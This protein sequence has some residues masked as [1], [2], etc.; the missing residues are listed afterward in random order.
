M[1]IRAATFASALAAAGP[2]LAGEIACW[3]DQGVLVAAAS[4]AEVAGDFIIDTG[5]PVSQLHN[6]RA[7]S[8]GLE[9]EQVQGAVRLAGLQAPQVPLAVV[10]LDA[11]TR[12]F[13]TPIAGVIG[14]DVLRDF[15]LEVSPGDCRLSLSPGGRRAPFPGAVSLALVW[16]DGAP[17]I[18]AAV[19]DGP[20]ARTV[21]LTPATGLD[22]PLR[23]AARLAAV[24][25]GEAATLAPYGGGRAELRALSLGGEIFEGLP[26]G[27]ADETAATDGA[28]GLS[29]LGRWRLRFDFPAGRLDL[30]APSSPFR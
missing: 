4:V 17:V 14:A 11:R 28:V 25:G 2:A 27:L 12:A 19:S 10:D 24:P 13:P 21:S 5:A 23:L 18:P 3:R 22:A 8:A 26:A 9:G 20:R 6:T 16:R 30:I 29:V 7:Q 1:M 15:V